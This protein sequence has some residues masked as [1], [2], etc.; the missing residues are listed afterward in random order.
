MPDQDQTPIPFSSNPPL[1][2]PRSEH[3]LS[4]ANI[5]ASAL[6]VLYR[7]KQAGFQAHLVGGG[8]RD[9]LLGREPKDFDVA[10]DARP[11]EVRQVFRN[12]RLIGRR[13]R[14]AHVHFGGEIIEVATFRGGQ[15]D[16]D[17]DGHLIE[18]GRIIRDNVYGTIEEDALRRDFTV[19]A[20]YYNIADFS[21][22]DYA[23]GLEDLRAGRLRLIGGDPERRYREDPVRMLRAVRFACKLGFSIDPACEQP[24]FDLPHLLGDIPVARLFEELLKLFL[25]GTSLDAFEKLRHYGLFAH[26]LPA[27]EAALARE[28]QAFPLTFVARGLANTD[29]RIQEVKPV[30]PAFLFAI[31]LWEP[32]RKRF[33]TL[34]DKGLAASEAMLLAIDE[35]GAGTRSLVAVPKRFGLPMREIWSLQP[36]FEQRDGKRPHRLMTHPRFR[37]AYDFLLLRAEAGEADPA[38]ADWWTRFQGVDED[39]RTQMTSGPSKRRRSRR[40]RRKAPT[41]DAAGDG[42]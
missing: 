1:I 19:N 4:R 15:V 24:L 21:V 17:D 39:G 30:T 18:N 12:C 33:Q 3:Q 23:G 26:L 28:E 2:V 37:A 32:V 10:T 29:R 13:F 38:L 31:L 8:V 36:R 41:V 22:I 40:R 34:L 25:A 9:L 35:V 27:T 42:A 7:L 6:K 11:E 16:E 14:L 20:L 5:S